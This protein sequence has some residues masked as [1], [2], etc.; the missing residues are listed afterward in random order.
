M[1]RPNQGGADFLEE[2]GQARHASL[3]RG[4]IPR[5]QEGQPAGFCA[6]TL[7]LGAGPAVMAVVA[8][9]TRP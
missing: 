4:G 1:A 2:H 5:A 8:C 7:G 3:R 9:H 6:P